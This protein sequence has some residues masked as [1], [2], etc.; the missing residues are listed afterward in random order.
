VRGFVDEVRVWPE[1]LSVDAVRRGMREAMPTSIKGSLV[2][3][4]DE[5]VQDSPVARR[6]RHLQQVQS[7]LS[8]HE[9][10]RQFELQVD[11]GTVL[12]KWIGEDP[13]TVGFTVERSEDGTTFQ[14]LSIV[15][16]NIDGPSSG[17]TYRYRDMNAPEAI[18]FYRVRQRYSDGVERVSAPIKVG[19]RID[20][21]SLSATLTGTYPNP[22]VSGTP[23]PYTVKQRSEIEITIWD[24]AGQRISLLY[25]GTRNP[26][27]HEVD[28][29]A[30]QYVDG[31]YFIRL[32][33]ET[34]VSSRQIVLKK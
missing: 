15:I 31:T 1:A 19:L 21:A 10:I 23:I 16:A 29:D 12:L 7:D 20:E 3:S 8:F 14:D 30:E 22:F 25:D 17:D 28:L 2:L 32:K 27:D 6:I 9:E 18:A 24:S 34:G 4:F 26:G 13:E 33:T 5:D 11:A